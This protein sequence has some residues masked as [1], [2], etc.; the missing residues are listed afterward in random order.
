MYDEEKQEPG[1][2]PITHWHMPGHFLGG[3]I[4]GT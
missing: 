2:G 1:L 3:A 4:F